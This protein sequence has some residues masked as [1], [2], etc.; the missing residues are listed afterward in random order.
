MG[1]KVGLY[2]VEKGTLSGTLATQPVVI[3]TELRLN[4]LMYSL[5]PSLRDV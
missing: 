3:P 5:A 4:L 2:D 1:P